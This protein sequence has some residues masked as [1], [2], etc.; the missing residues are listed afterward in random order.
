[1][2]N[3]HNW[4]AKK[5]FDSFREHWGVFVGCPSDLVDGRLNIGRL[6]L[7]DC[8]LL[9]RDVELRSCSLCELPDLLVIVRHCRPYTTVFGAK[10]WQIHDIQVY[11]LDAPPGPEDYGG[12]D[13]EPVN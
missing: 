5:Y 4:R 11:P 7:V 10:K 9:E 8:S 2:K 13:W 6:S 12:M 1:M 3:P